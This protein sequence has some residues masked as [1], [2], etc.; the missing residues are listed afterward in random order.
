MAR[1]VRD[2]SLGSRTARTE[3][4]PRGKPYYRTI[5]P[6][7]L[8]LGYRKPRGGAGKWL[9]RVYAGSGA[10]RLHKIGVADDLSDADGKVILSFK[11]AQDAARKLMV[12]QAG[13]G[14]GTVADAVAAY[15]ESLVDDGRAESAIKRTRYSIEAHILPGLGRF[16]LAKLTREQLERWHKELARAPIR[17]RVRKGEK[18]RYRTLG[19][20]ADQRRARRVSANRVRA[21]LFAA[22]NLAFKNGHVASDVAWRQVKAFRGVDRARVRY[23]TIDE[24]KRLINAARAE[25]RPLLQAALLTGARYGSLVQL[26]VSDFDADAGTLRLRTRKGNGQERVF[27]A[28]LT[29]EAQLFFREACA[30][31]RG[32]DLIFTHADGQPWGKS[33]QDVPMREASRGARIHPPISFNVAR[34]SFASLSVMAGCPLMVVAE[35]LGHVDA[36]MVQKHY[37]H[38]APSFVAEQIRKAA[39]RYG[40][41]PGNVRPL[42][43]RR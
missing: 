25:F 21:T 3:L 15:L 40:I 20:D 35:C 41:K 16:E 13:G 6:G 12:Q 23:L 14:V 26:V 18:Q 32:S 5:E 31:K 30:G 27:H 28:H 34:H 17:L 37:G 7:L 9:A 24:A 11:Q 10:Y 22:L 33:H 43:G 19:D 38:L 4:K 29:A 1:T 36:R 8:H 42:H 39:P 2:T